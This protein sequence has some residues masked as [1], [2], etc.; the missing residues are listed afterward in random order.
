MT[1]GQ[2]TATDRQRSWSTDGIQAAERFSY[3]REAICQA[4]MTLTPERP[5]TPEF[6]ARLQHVRLGDG[7]L[8]RVIF[9]QHTVRRLRSDIAGSDRRCFYLNLKLA[10]R[11]GIFQAG[12]ELTLSPGQVGI[13]DSGR[14][15]E[16]RHDRGPKLGLASFWVPAE[17]LLS[18][19][20][21]SFDILPARVSDDAEIGPLIVQTAR[22]LNERALEMTDEDARRLFDVLLDLVAF[23]LSRTTRTGAKPAAS[24]AEATTLTLHSSIEKRLR[25]SGLKVADVAGDLGISSRYLHA[26]LARTGTT[27]SD[28]VMARRLDAIAADL[29]NPA[30]AARDI[31]SIALDWGFADLSHFSRC[32]KKRFGMRARDWRAAHTG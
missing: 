32:F 3:Y 15:V 8:N 16:L 28:H 9:P 30:H 19:L 25:K 18:R 27:F 11:C 22:T 13:F 5:A 10:G 14:T 6:S 24:I 4:F 1:A 29:R 7:A 26:L 23:S 20:P 17:A 2:G 21:P 12:R 31:G